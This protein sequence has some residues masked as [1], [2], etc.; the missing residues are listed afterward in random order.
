MPR[1]IDLAES[2][3]C[4]VVDTG[5]R[6]NFPT[7]HPLNQ[8]SRSRAAVAQADVI[9]LLEVSDAWGQLN[10][11]SDRI[12]RSNRPVYK[13]GAK[14]ITIGNR[15]MLI[16][17]NTQD[18]GRY[19]PVD[20][21][22]SGDGEASLPYLTEQVKKLMDDGKKASASERGKKLAAA[23]SKVMDDLLAQAT[24]GWDSTPITTARMC[25]ELYAQIRDDDWSLVGSSTGLAWP[26]LLWD[27]KKPY[28]WNGGSGGAGVGYNAPASLGAALANKK[29]G[30]LTVTINGDGDF[31]MCPGT[32]W[33]AAHHQIP[34]LYVMNNN[35]AWHQEYMYL[36]AMAGRHQRGARNT[37]I[38][39]TITDPNIDYANLARSFGVYGEGPISDPKELGPALKRALAVVRRGEPALIDVVTDPR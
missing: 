28:S 8:S 37:R 2:L 34:L 27:M 14:I 16:K 1:L 21:A 20:L 10:A 35:R 29:H 38:G 24:I 39:T 30:R 17:G 19:Q 6:M 4:A 3:Q 9:L 12:V 7:Q 36:Q 33:T 18:F 25:A 26:R 15:D 32:L 23:K 31:M 11:H 13:P 5:G 22:I